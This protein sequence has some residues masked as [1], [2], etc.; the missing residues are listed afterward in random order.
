MQW[1]NSHNNELELQFEP[2]SLT[3]ARACPPDVTRR[4]HRRA[5]CN[6]TPRS[7]AKATEA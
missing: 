4:F 7:H 1:T 6:S 2:L 5:S 3:D